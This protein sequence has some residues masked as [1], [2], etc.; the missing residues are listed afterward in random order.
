[1]A[2]RYLQ[3]AKYQVDGRLYTA[4]A[5]PNESGGYELR[6]S[7]FK[8]TLGTKDVSYFAGPSGMIR[9]VP[10]V[11]VYEGHFDFLAHLAERRLDHVDDPALVLN[12]VAM[13]ERGVARLRA[14]GLGVSGVIG[15]RPVLQ[16]YFDHDAAGRAALGHL[17]LV[18]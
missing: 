4:L 14:G 17:A 10:V 15:N 18:S 7:G 16:T 6:N 13:V 12:S 1:M 9:A 11:S 8:G 2:R 3:Q 5:F